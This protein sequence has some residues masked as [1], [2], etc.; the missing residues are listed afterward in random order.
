MEILEKFADAFA[1][2]KDVKKEMAKVIVGQ[3]EPVNYIVIS[4]FS[5]G[6]LLLESAPGLA[7]SRMVEALAR[8]INIPFKRIQL[9]P[10]MLP[11]D[12]IGYEM[13]VFGTQDFVTRKGPIFGG[14]VL[15]DELNRSP[16]KTQAAFMQAMQSRQV[17]IGDTTHN[18]NK[19]FTAIATENPI[20]TGGTFQIAEAVLDRF[21]AKTIFSYPSLAEED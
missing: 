11:Q 9:T 13:P 17:T 21:M 7:K 20:E 16:E 18:L 3:E 4:L 19:I 8:I 14:L 12:I 15:L 5:H 1:K 10:D 2:I 6:H